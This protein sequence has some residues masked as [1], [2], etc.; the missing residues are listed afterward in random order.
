MSNNLKFKI[1]LKNAL[2]FLKFHLITKMTLKTLESQ[3]KH[4][5]MQEKKER[6]RKSLV[7]KKTKS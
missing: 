1:I 7:M 6:G 5:N 4:L 2:K 3:K